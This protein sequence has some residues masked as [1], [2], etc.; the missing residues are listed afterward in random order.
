MKQATTRAAH[1]PTSIG[2]GIAFL[3]SARS[4]AATIPVQ[5]A[6]ENSRRIGTSTPKKTRPSAQVLAGHFP[7]LA[8]YQDGAAADPLSVPRRLKCPATFDIGRWHSGRHT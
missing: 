6:I 4:V 3:A 5:R 2:G 1:M 8:R 7:E